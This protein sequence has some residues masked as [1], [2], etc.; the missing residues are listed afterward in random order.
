MVPR[1]TCCLRPFTS[2]GWHGVFRHGSLFFGSCQ[3]CIHNSGPRDL[4]CPVSL[5][6]LYASAGYIFQCSMPRMGAFYIMKSSSDF[7]LTKAPSLPRASAMITRG[8]QCGPLRS[9]NTLHSL[10]LNPHL[11]LEYHLNLRICTVLTRLRSAHGM[12]GNETLSVCRELG[13]PMIPRRDW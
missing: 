10:I 1:L 4:G 2:L 11:S 12:M 9:S 3:N 13:N 6:Y 7:A 8:E 5:R